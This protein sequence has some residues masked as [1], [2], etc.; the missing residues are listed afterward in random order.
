MTSG[1]RATA[2]PEVPLTAAVC[3]LFCSACTIY[4]ASQEDP[5][6][7]TFLATRMGLTEGELYC[8]GCRSERRPQHCLACTFVSCAA[9]RGLAFCGECEDL[10]CPEFAAFVAERPHRNDIYRDLERINEIGVQ[11][12]MAE[13]TARYTCPE[14]GTLNSAYDIKCRT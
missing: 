12:W 10:P 8:E 13:A 14:C 2:T 6:R 1:E 4:I 11:A 9:G 5:A 7:L 3:G